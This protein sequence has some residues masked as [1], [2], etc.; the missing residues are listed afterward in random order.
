VIGLDIIKGLSAI[1]E[2]LG[3]K[4]A[5]ILALPRLLP[6]AA[7][8]GIAVLERVCHETRGGLYA[9]TYSCCSAPLP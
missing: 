5:A 6:V 8:R 3:I 1:V 7:L 4:L 9:C 2:L